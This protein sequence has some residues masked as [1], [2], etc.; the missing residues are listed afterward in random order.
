MKKIPKRRVSL[1]VAATLGSGA[2]AGM[3]PA[4]ALAQAPAPAA[5]AE[6]IERIQVT[7]TRI[8]LET[9]ESESPVQVL[10]AQDIK[11]TGLTNIADV[12]NQLPQV[13]PDYGQMLSNGSF[14]TATVDLRGL[15]ASRTL[16]LIDGR[17]VPAG[18][19]RLWA[20]DL[21]A[22]PSPL[23]QRVDV[24]TGG[25]SSIYG[26][27]AIAG[28]VNFIMNDHFEGLQLDYNA[29]GYNHQQHNSMV[30]SIV[31]GRAETNPAQY[32]VPGNV[33]LDGVTQDFSMTLGGNFA[34]AKGNA[35]VYFEYRHSQPVLQGSR[36]FSA[37]SLSSTPD[38]LVCGGSSTSFP[39]RFLNPV[40][41]KNWTIADAAGNVRPYLA[42]TDAF[43]FG[44]YNYYQVP[45]ERYLANFFAHYDALPNLRVYTEFDFMDDKTVLQIAPSGA[46]FGQSVTLYDSNPFLS[47]SFKTAF[48]IAPDN[49]ADVI[50]GRRNV[51]GGGRQD[52]PRHTDYRIVIG[53]KGD[54]LDGKWDY[55]LWWQSGKVVYQDVYLADFS[56]ER[57]ARS[58]NV[59][60]DPRSGAPVCASVLDGSDPQCVPW[61]IFQTGGVTPAALTYLQTSGFQSGETAQQVVGLHLSTDLGTAYG[62]KLPLAKTGIGLAL[63]VERRTEKLTLNTDPAF[64]IPDLAGQ[65][66]PTIGVTGQYTVNEAFAELRVPIFEAQKW[67]DLLSFNASY[68]Y[69]SYTTGPQTN[70]YGLGAEWAPVKEARL[71]G[72]YQ[73]AVRAPNIIELFTPRG[74]SIFG[75]DHDPCG[76]AMTASVAQCQLTGLSPSMYGSS[77]LDNPANQYNQ[78]GGGNPQLKPET[79]TSYTVGLVLQ[80]TRN[81]SATI[82]YWN[83]SVKASISQLNA[84]VILNDCLSI[85]LLCNAIHRDALGTLWLQGGGFIDT[86]NV[87]IGSTRTS[88]IDV[89]AN[90]T[91]ALDSYGSLG[92]AFTGTWLNEF[93]TESIPGLGSYD[94]AGLFGLVCGKPLPRWRNVL[95]TTWNTPW[96][97]NAG[98]RW[99]YFS[100]VN[101]DASSSNPQLAG[102][103]NPG[104][105]KIG[106]Q[107]YLD[108][109]GQWNISKNFTLRGGVNNVFDH[110]PPVITG[111]GGAYYNGNTFPQV[112]D[113]LGRN[114]FIN[115]QAKF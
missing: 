64:S 56:I 115:L 73:R 101:V 76:P 7:G 17:R 23:I 110:D 5:P 53:A 10:T 59:V 4:P 106:A 100:S 74:I 66:S 51:E 63:G 6:R 68:R 91:L 94:C 19:P 87:N 84:N 42:N 29:N 44:P 112:Y 70:T 22:I 46:F 79:S 31:A 3:A 26:S 108:L 105:A 48:G 24:L 40:T 36:D 80:P 96:N 57:I 45:D 67:A 109:F 41:G 65:G 8:P 2:F 85:G 58:L 97:W 32:Q 92:L 61:N 49:P 50:V 89:T 34:G 114:F 11:A 77:L 113:A 104:D 35:T 20:T 39:G 54:I 103:Y 33:G 14:G 18:D 25:A 38:S 111:L 69:S 78:L 107:S 55:D 12:L 75:L 27:D 9:L 99:R 90:Y 72:T 95:T 43:N 30:S 15:G 71:R 52:V 37:C 86:A 88:G 98:F 47:P 13:I 81:F 1:A 60:R 83:I 28:V 82:D 21:N 16:V 62:W 93:V 102:D